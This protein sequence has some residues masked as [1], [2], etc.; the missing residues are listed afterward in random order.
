MSPL[1]HHGTPLTWTGETAFYWLI[2]RSE[3][4]GRQGRE[5]RGAPERATQERRKR[6]KKNKTRHKLDKTLVMVS[7]KEK[8][9]SSYHGP[10]YRD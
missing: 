6:K 7:S 1:P 5:E 9:Q 8:P 2:F 10:R 4:E 3:R